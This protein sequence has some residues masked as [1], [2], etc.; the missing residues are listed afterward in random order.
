MNY[1]YVLIC[2]KLEW[3]DIVIYIDEYEAKIQ[4]IN[5]PNKRVEIFSKTE[6][7]YKPTYCYYKNGNLIET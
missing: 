1:I 3:E 4:S 7:G 2:D 5:N 6:N